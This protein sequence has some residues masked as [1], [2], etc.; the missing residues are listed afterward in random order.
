MRLFRHGSRRA[1]IGQ[2]TSCGVFEATYSGEFCIKAHDALR[3]EAMNAG[4]AAAVF[5]LRLDEGQFPEEEKLRVG[6]YNYDATSAPGAIIVRPDQFAVFSACAKTAAQVGV[7][8]SVWLVAHA[9][10]AYE[11]AIR[12]AL[13]KQQELRL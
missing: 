8:R 4:A 5:V 9:A 11:W 1:T 3:Q 12:Q 10:K 7:M 6:P 2:I 13:A